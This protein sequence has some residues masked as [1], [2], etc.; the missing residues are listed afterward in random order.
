MK[1]GPI[2][3]AL[4]AVLAMSGA[5]AAF[6]AN[7]SPYVTIAQAKSSTG[8][9]LHLAG[10]LDKKSVHNNLANHVLSFQIKDANGD[11]VKRYGSGDTPEA[12]EKD[13][14]LAS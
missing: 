6:M 11:V 10:D 14:N 2:V 12:I 5:V 1:S 4:V 13:L 3:T 7:A 9:R 8:D